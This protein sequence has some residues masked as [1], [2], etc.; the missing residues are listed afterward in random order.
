MSNIKLK[1]RIQSYQEISDYKLLNRLPL[2]ITLNGKA[3]NKVTELLDK[4]YCANFAECMLSTTLKLCYEIEG[5]IFGYQFNDQIVIVA[6]N[7]Q[8]IDTLA[9]FDNRIQKI[10]SA[11][12]SIATRHFNKCIDSLQLNLMGESIF[13]CQVFVVPNISEAINT[14]I[15]N[16][17]YN[18]HISIQMACVYELLKKYDKYIIKEMLNGLTID[19]KIDLLHQECDIDFDLYPISF[20]RGA[21]CY[22]APKINNEGSMKNK[23]IINPD[24]PIFSKDQTFLGNLFRQGSDIFRKDNF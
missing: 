24:L 21:A 8:N 7:D 16:Q 18:F 3:F 9:W 4:P 10:V 17:Q 20:R 14:I 11:V 2:V 15:Y 23:W 13:T 12:S 22:K 19:E 1:D 5:A 6:R